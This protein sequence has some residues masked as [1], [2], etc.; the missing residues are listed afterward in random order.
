MTFL[1]K[2]ELVRWGSQKK[3]LIASGVQSRRLFPRSIAA[4][5]PYIA[6]VFVF[7]CQ[8]LMS[9]KQYLSA[10]HLEKAR[11]KRRSQEFWWKSIVRKVPKFPFDWR[12]VRWR[13]LKSLLSNEK[14]GWHISKNKCMNEVYVCM[15]YENQSWRNV[16][17]Y[18]W[19]LWV[20][21]QLEE[22]L[23]IFKL[24]SFSPL[25]PAKYLLF[26]FHNLKLNDWDGVSPY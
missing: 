11:T 22:W 16:W 26:D 20:G 1:D 4:C 6:A 7:Y 2:C 12:F 8:K 21:I 5:A 3:S 19:W 14:C 13:W 15:Q 24:F 17:L 25:W 23:L 10:I 18:T 9:S